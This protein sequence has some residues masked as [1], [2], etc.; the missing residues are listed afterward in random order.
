MIPNSI[1]H[2]T[3]NE[4][5]FF[6]DMTK[7]RQKCQIHT[8][9]NASTYRVSSVKVRLRRSFHFVSFYC[10]LELLR[11]TNRMS[12]LPLSS[13]IELLSVCVLCFALYVCDIRLLKDM[14]VHR[15]HMLGRRSYVYP[16]FHL[17]IVLYTRAECLNV[18]LSFGVPCMSPCV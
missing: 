14:Y 18:C 16:Y 8:I 3:S 10:C 17:F 13:N 5:Y 9:F 11:T 1:E 2:R 7:A 6:L 12:V 4:K 15:I